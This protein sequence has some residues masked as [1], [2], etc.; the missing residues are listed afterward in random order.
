M[1]Q[2]DNYILKNLHV[3]KNPIFLEK[4]WEDFEIACQNKKLILYGI[5]S[6]TNFIWIRCNNKFVISAAIDNNSSKQNHTLAD[7][8][9]ESDLKESKNIR[10]ET[11]KILKL[12]NPDDVVILISSHRY[13]QEIAV[14]LEN[15]HFYL[16]F[17]VLN[18]EYNYRK[19]SIK[20]N[21]LFETEDTYLQTLAQSYVEKHPIQNNKVVFCGMGDYAGHEKYITEEL[22]NMNVD[23]EIVW[24]S[25]KFIKNLPKRIRFVYRGIQRYGSTVLIYPY[26][27]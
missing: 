11:K 5:S 7:F 18:L 25:Y 9:D 19:F 12:Y 13:Y 6:L 3:T 10:V 17:S 14:D 1:S 24:V 16:Y 23:L 21:L 27:I 22:L 8:F 2:V 26:L 4:T 20:N 15:Q